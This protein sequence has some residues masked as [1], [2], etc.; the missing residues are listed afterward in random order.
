[1]NTRQWL[2]AAIALQ[3]LLLAA[4]VGRHGYTLATGT[5]VL[6]ETVPVDPWDFFRGRYVNLRYAI[7]VLRS[8]EVTM[9]GTPYE[10]GQRVWVTLRRG[11][12][13]WTAVRVSEERPQAGP[14]LAVVRATV[15]SAWQGGETGWVIHLRYGIERFYV[16]ED[17]GRTLENPDGVLTVEAVVDAFGRAALRRVFLNG[18]PVRWR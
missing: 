10:S 12:Q 7:S 14:D 5:P 8:D 11:D 13:Y 17:Q 18:E 2:W 1:M 9:V 16:P 15:E 3:V 6:L 4:M